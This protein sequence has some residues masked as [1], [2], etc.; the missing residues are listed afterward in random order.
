MKKLFILILISVCLSSCNT[1]VPCATYSDRHQNY[2]QKSKN[3]KKFYNYY[4]T[5]DYKKH[6]RDIERRQKAPAKNY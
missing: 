3:A 5:S 6:R 4:K 1:Y 2:T